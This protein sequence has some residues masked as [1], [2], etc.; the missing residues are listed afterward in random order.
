MQKTIN[1]SPLGWFTDFWTIEGDNISPLHKGIMRE[2]PWPVF[3]NEQEW[4]TMM[5]APVQL[6]LLAV[7][8]LFN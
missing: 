5:A 1:E 3:V 6:E 7:G 2:T 4:L 8:F